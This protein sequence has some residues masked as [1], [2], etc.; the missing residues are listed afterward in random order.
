[1]VRFNT[2]LRIGLLCTLIACVAALIFPKKGTVIKSEPQAEVMEARGGLG[3]TVAADTQIG[4]ETGTA[5][6]IE[7][8][9]FSKPKMLLYTSYTVQKG[10][11]IGE[12]AQRF[13]LE[14]GTLIS[15]NNITN[16]RTLQIGQV[17]KIP[18]QDGVLVKVERIE[19]EKKLPTLNEFIKGLSQNKKYQGIPPSEP[20]LQAFAG[21]I[22]SANELFMD[23]NEKF[24][25]ETKSVFIPGIKVNNL[26]LQEINGDIFQ[27]PA[28]GY[29]TDVYGYRY[30]PFGS[31]SR[32]F[33]NG[34]DISARTGTPI[35]A[36]MAGQ[37]TF[38][39]WSD[40][41]GNYVVI[42]HSGGYRTLYAHMSVLRTKTGAYINAGEQ[43]GDVGSTGRSTAPHL[44]FTV[45]KNGV[46]VNPRLL[47]R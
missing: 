15:I 14:Q 34:M 16:A 19:T 26:E 39:G 37:V 18:N 1:M 47:L 22:Q 36:A 25:T 7:P 20:E 29:I 41:Y 43:I 31:G 12:I 10:D 44:H 8:E 9:E 46:T 32:E 3:L 35:R 21:S 13:A 5:V 38:A 30:D 27:W 6:E 4:M 33:H 42:R 2:F 17:I 28:R 23:I 40:S 11:T 24:G 45:Y